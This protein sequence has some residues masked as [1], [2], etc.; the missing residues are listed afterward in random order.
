MNNIWSGS[1]L[2]KEDQSSFAATLDDGDLSG[3][4]V[5]LLKLNDYVVGYA[6]F[7]KV[8]SAKLNHWIYIAT[9]VKIILSDDSQ[10]ISFGE[11]GNFIFDKFLGENAP[12]LYFFLTDLPKKAGNRLQFAMIARII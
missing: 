12:I 4:D 6:D 11:L 5:S 2:F 7:Q 8:N 10:V 1:G 9:S 3:A